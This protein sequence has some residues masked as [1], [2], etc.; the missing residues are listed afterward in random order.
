MK[1]DDPKNTCEHF[2]HFGVEGH[3][4]WVACSYDSWEAAHKQEVES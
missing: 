4:I 3:H 1:A 2:K